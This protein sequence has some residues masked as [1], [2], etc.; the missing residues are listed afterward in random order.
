MQKH[1]IRGSLI[2]DIFF[3]EELDRLRID[4]KG[5]IG[6]WQYPLLN[7]D[8]TVALKEKQQVQSQDVVKDK[9]MNR[10]LNIPRRLSCTDFCLK[11][12]SADSNPSLDNLRSSLFA[13]LQRGNSFRRRVSSTEIGLL[14]TDAASTVT[15][16]FL[17]KTL[18]S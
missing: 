7:A 2:A 15:Q 12:E 5:L 17:E 16:S 3:C 14:F 4:K 10:G 13:K 8:N 9:V 6:L 18:R 11:N 1:V